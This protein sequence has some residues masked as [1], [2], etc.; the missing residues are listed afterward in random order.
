[1]K[2][3]LALLFAALMVFSCFACNTQGPAE[4]FALNVNISSEP[5][6]IDP[7]LNTAVD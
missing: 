6:S 7:A 5:E 1:M 4:G 2:K 3:V